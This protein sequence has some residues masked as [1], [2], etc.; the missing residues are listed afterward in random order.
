[1]PYYLRAFQVGYGDFPA[2]ARA[3][4]RFLVRTDA[5]APQVPG[6]RTYSLRLREG[7]RYWVLLDDSV[8][9]KKSFCSPLN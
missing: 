6:Y 1:L 7:E 5:S 8:P 9:L 3:P 2:A 4:L